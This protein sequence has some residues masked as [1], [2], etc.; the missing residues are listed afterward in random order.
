MCLPADMRVCL[1][2]T[3]SRDSSYVGPHLLHRGTVGEPKAQWEREVGA[4]VGHSVQPGP[5]DTGPTAGHSS[6]HVFVRLLLGRE[7]KRWRKK[8]MAE[9]RW[10]LSG[11]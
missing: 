11:E 9:A 8:K 6:Q 10:M 1:L 3:L 7:K 4:S 5:L 2:P